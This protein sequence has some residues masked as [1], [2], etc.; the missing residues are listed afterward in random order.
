MRLPLLAALLALLWGPLNQPSPAAAATTLRLCTGSPGKTYIR[1]GEKLAEL[2][3]RA[4]MGQL[5]V[6]VVPTG[7]SLD[8]LSRTLAGACDAFIAQGDAI[9]FFDAR[10]QPGARQQ[11]EVLGDLYKELGLLL[12]HR[13]S[14]ID[15]L[16]EAG[17]AVIAAGDTGTGSL[18][19]ILNLQLL[20]PEL[21]GNIRIYPANGFEGALAV[22]EGKAACVF[23]VIAPQSDLVQTLNDN[24][25]TGA[26]LYFAEI[27]NSALEDFEIDGKQIYDI[28]TFNDER[29][30]NL[31][32]YG[33]PETLAISAVLGVSKAYLQQHPQ[34]RST[35]AMLLLMGAKEI[36]AV[37]YGASRRFRD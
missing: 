37:A 30:P 25:R 9:A 1:V 4:S 7:G 22:I 16:D 20:E 19:T 14:G 2:A 36:E 13:S 23:D 18:A 8:N 24:E 15:D 27:D 5:A 21:Y 26:Q 11:F 32:R 3:Q 28:V 17:D 35:L 34:V 6:E 33:D 12:C 10:I 29:Y 31:A